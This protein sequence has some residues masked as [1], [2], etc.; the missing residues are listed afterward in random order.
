MKD[1]LF[2]ID[3]PS[4][5]SDESAVLTTVY[6]NMELCLVRSILEGEGIPY[7]VRDRG[8]GGVVRIMAGDSPFGC[9]ILVPADMLEK[10]TELLDAYRN[11]EAVDEEE[12]N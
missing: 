2:G 1:F 12:G 7:R 9:D 3:Q 6:G 8:A 10:A 4:A 11:G 5:T